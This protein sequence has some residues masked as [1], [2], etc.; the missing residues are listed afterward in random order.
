MKVAFVK[1]HERQGTLEMHS[2]ETCKVKILWPPRGAR[3]KSMKE[4]FDEKELQDIVHCT[5]QARRRLKPEGNCIHKFK[6]ELSQCP[7]FTSEA[8]RKPSPFL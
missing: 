5:G 3:L 6:N 1:G 7:P 8:I 2:H 4:A